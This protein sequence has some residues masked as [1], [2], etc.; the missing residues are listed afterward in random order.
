VAAVMMATIPVFI[1]LSEIV[2]LRTMRLT[3]WLAIALLAGLAGVG[4]LVGP[5]GG[6]D[7]VP[8]DAF[9]ALALILAAI[10]WSI[11]TAYTRKFTLPASKPMSAGAQMFSGGVLLILASATLGE[12]RG[13]QP[14][15]VSAGAW[16]ALAY[17]TVAG[18]I[19][20]FTA[21]TW[22]IHHVA[23]T[24]VGTY[25]YVNPVVAVA[26]G[27]F[28]GGESIGSRTLLGALLVLTSVVVI[29]VT[30]KPRPG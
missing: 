15:L 9:G 3:A 20:A 4:V 30:P 2:F 22:L 7:E 28:L 6:F 14:N 26:L 12:F 16:L 1:A 13:F 19:V 23:P 27:Y 25:A 24:K 10:S 18:S 5:A 8:I 29:G 21:F 17:L 11:A